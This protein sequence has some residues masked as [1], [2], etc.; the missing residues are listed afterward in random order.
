MILSTHELT[1]LIAWDEPGGWL[2]TKSLRQPALFRDGADDMPVAIEVVNKKSYTGEHKGRAKPGIEEGYKP[3]WHNA[4]WAQGYAATHH[5][6][7]DNV[8]LNVEKFQHVHFVFAVASNTISVFAD[9]FGEH[10]V[11][12]EE[13]TRDSYQKN[14]EWCSAFAYS[15]NTK[16]HNV[17]SGNAPYRR[18]NQ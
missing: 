5:D 2:A 9:E 7:H 14:P 1:E 15:N 18:S 3:S 6:G 8:A 12:E 16:S 11:E 4:E 10:E 13:D 17:E